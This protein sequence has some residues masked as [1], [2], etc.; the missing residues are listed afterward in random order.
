MLLINRYICDMKT[1]PFYLTNRIPP[2]FF[3]DRET[4]AKQ[5]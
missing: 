4:E 1:N 5:P 3:C 2:Q